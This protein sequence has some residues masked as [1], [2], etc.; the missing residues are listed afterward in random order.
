MGMFDGILSAVT[1]PVASLGS[2]LVG[3]AG[4]YFGTQSANQ[5]NT[6]IA[7]AANQQSLTNHTQNQDWLANQRA[8]RQH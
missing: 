8:V 2:A 7:N 4:S 5:A 1:S 3:A 6:D